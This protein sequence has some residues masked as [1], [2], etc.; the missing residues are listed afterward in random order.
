MTVV[1]SQH[2]SSLGKLTKFQ[3]YLHACI[4]TGTH[5]Y[6]GLVQIMKEVS[7]GPTQT[8]GKGLF[9][10]MNSEGKIKHAYECDCS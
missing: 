10:K 1:Q 3:R 5:T 8:I 4:C 9:L 7:S 2:L 6:S